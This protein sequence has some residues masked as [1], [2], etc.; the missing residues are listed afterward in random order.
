MADKNEAAR[1]ADAAAPDNSE[2]RILER[3]ATRRYDD[4]E[5]NNVASNTSMIINNWPF[6]QVQLL[7]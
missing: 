6:A 4:V 1:A 2:T 3:L 5:M 7:Q